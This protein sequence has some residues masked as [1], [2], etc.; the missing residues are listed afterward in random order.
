MEF[1]D[2][3]QLT[4]N[5]PH[6]FF[7]YYETSPWSKNG[8]YFVC[9]ETDFQDHMPSMGDKARIILL[10]LKEETYRVL[11]ET[12]GWNFQQGCL[13]H[14]LPSE[15]NNKIV[16][17]DCDPKGIFSRIIDIQSEEERKLPRAI[18]AIAHSKDLA[19]CVN[20][21]RLRKNRPVVSYPSEYDYATGGLHPED[22]GV[23]LMN[24]KSGESD[25][26]A[27]FDEIW[28]KNKITREGQDLLLKGQNYWFNH[29]GFSPEDDRFFF[30]ARFTNSYKMLVSSMWTMNTDGSDP[31]LVVDFNNQLSHFGWYSNSTLIVTMKY[32][33]ETNYSHVLIKDRDGES[34]A[35]SPQRLTWNGHPVFSPD[36]KYLAT[37]TYIV[38]NKRFVYIFDMKA[39]DLLIVAEFE[40]PKHI[41][42]DIRCDPHPR[43]KPDGSQLS[44]D[45]LGA[46]GRQVYAI[47]IK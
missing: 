27:S 13:L 3:I 26:I 6:H 10:D 24:L 22:D 31:Y 23:F 9:L 16:F 38:K 28:N 33:K 47:D 8:R 14:W 41:K 19:L 36:K 35:I 40:N 29:L 46:H 25:L 5:Y 42:E 21:A 39:E 37:D 17:N 34:H 12:Q 11:T 44:F 4:P 20:F 30:L 45:G 15:P 7:G 2:P 1:S 32:L 18:N 43:W